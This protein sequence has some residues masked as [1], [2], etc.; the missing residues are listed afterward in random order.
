[1]PAKE[2]ERLIGIFSTLP[3]MGPRSARRAVLSLLNQP[4]VRIEPLIQTLQEVL[5][6]VQ[7]CPIC[8]N[9]DT[10]VPCSVCSDPRRDKKQLCVVQD[11]ADLWALERAGVFH[12]IYHV[13]GGVLSAINGIGP[14][15][16]RLSQLVERVQSGEVEEIILALPA[17]VDGQTTAH[18]VAQR[19]EKYPVRLTTLARGVPVGGE[20]DYLDDGT[21]Q[22]AL[23]SRRSL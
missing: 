1:M 5:D 20:L 23:K 22:M 12:G 19:L 13:L 14:E 8:G 7:E 3:T 18:Y 10:N 17:T 11:M 21:L 9:R 15:E 16:L 2:I 4:K 6:K